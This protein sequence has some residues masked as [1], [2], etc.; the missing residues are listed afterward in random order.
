MPLQ[1]L[2]P[3]R[4]PL[5]IL[6][7]L[8]LTL[9]LQVQ[10]GHSLPQG[11]DLHANWWTQ[12]TGSNS[13]GYLTEAFRDNIFIPAMDSV[14]RHI[15]DFN[16]QLKAQGN[17]DLAMGIAASFVLLLIIMYATL[18]NKKISNLTK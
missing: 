11:F 9:S 8:T 15:D 17:F 3:A 13:Y 10:Q 2:S 5:L 7:A 1:R 16:G 14:I 6:Q 18:Q 12:D 4:R